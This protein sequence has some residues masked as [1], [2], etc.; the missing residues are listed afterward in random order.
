MVK[1]STEKSPTVVNNGTNNVSLSPNGEARQVIELQS[2]S[3]DQEAHNKQDPMTVEHHL[4]PPAD[5]AVPQYDD[6]N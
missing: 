1:R 2:R 6:I 5:E 3:H 4:C